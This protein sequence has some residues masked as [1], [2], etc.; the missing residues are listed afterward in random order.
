MPGRETLM[1]KSMPVV[2]PVA[3]GNNIKELRIE[4]KLSVRDLQRYFGFESPQAIYLWQQ[5]KTVPSVDHLCAL[6]A[7]F[8]TPVEEIVV[9]TEVSEYT[10]S[11]TGL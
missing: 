11:E 2:N 5:G 3:T 6:G 9:L 7:L 1:K 10:K 8:G 4:K